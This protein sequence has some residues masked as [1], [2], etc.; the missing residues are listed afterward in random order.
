MLRAYIASSIRRRWHSRRWRWW[1]PAFGFDL[2]GSIEECFDQI[3]ILHQ[4]II[5]ESHLP[6]LFQDLRGN[7]PDEGISF[8]SS[9]SRR[10]GSWSRVSDSLS[11][12]RWRSIESG[13]CVFMTAKESSQ[14]A[15]MLLLG[16]RCIPIS[17]SCGS[18]WFQSRALVRQ[19]LS[20]L[21]LL[22]KRLGLLF[23]REG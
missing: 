15:M 20:L 23:V 16:V 22:L 10:R 6:H 4:L 7:T 13:R 9:C 19:L 12:R 18:K 5:A 8:S 2:L 3:G 17:Y 1:S 11:W 21:H 14:E